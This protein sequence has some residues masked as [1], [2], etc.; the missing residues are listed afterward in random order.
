MKLLYFYLNVIK[1]QF[2][3]ILH[4]TFISQVKY[5]IYAKNAL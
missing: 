2:T 4:L 5:I 3:Y 1:I